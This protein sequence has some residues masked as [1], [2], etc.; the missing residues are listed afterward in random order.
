MADDGT[1]AREGLRGRQVVTA[2]YLPFS[3]RGG[4]D[5]QLYCGDAGIVLFNES[6]SELCPQDHAGP[7]RREH[8]RY[9]EGRNG[10]QVHDRPFM[11][12]RPDDAAPRQAGGAA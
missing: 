2:D 7:A 11:E 1:G 6:C 12:E 9:P 4:H 8:R 3:C 10:S 5:S